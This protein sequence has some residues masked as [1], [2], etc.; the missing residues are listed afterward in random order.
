MSVLFSRFIR[1]AARKTAHTI[2]S[3]PQAREKAMQAG[4]TVY[5]EAK[6]VA[7]EKDKARA[8]GRSVRRLFN[9]FQNGGTIGGN[10]QKSGDDDKSGSGDKSG[11]NEET[12]GGSRTES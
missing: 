8:A 7:R 4:R 10:E 6:G 1:Y 12:S 5:D 3:N 2:A 9:S 11:G